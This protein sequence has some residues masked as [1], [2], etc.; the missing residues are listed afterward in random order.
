LF[1][2]DDNDLNE[3][4]H[5]ASLYDLILNAGTSYSIFFITRLYDKTYDCRLMDGIYR[6]FY[7]EELLNISSNSLLLRNI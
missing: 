7:V 6:D 3:I 5:L 4:I 2:H 1:K